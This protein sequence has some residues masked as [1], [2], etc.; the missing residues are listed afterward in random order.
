VRDWGKGPQD[1]DEIERRFRELTKGI[2][3]ANKSG[4]GRTGSGNRLFAGGTT[5]AALELIDTKTTSRGV[6]AHIYRPAGKPIRLG[7]R[8]A[9]R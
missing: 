6:V 8:R 5:P 1:P 2:E 7:H 9:R 3:L 4:F